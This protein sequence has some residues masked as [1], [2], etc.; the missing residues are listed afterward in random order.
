MPRVARPSG[1]VPPAF[2][3]AVP[4]PLVASL[5]QRGPTTLFEVFVSGLLQNSRT[6]DKYRLFRIRSPSEQLDLLRYLGFSCRV[7]PPTTAT[8]A[9]QTPSILRFRAAGGTS[10]RGSSSR[11][12]SEPGTCPPAARQVPTCL[13]PASL[14]RRSVA[15][16]GR[17]RRGGCS[18]QP[19][20]AA[21]GY[22]QSPGLLR[23]AALPLILPRLPG[24]VPLDSPDCHSFPYRSAH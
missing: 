9:S 18:L 5:L 17:R 6:C 20:A 12:R 7:P 15:A 3:P 8:A 4:L 22:R 11:L 13:V 19:P 1:G 10:L 14:L 24:L 2:P 16:G 21:A 23:Q